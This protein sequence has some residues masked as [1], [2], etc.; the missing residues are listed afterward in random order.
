[1]K[2]IFFFF[3]FAVSHAGEAQI[4]YS[5][6]K[7]GKAMASANNNEV[8]LA[9]DVLQLKFDSRQGKLSVTSFTDKPTNR[10]IQFAKDAP[11]FSIVLP[12]GTR[13]TSAA[14][15][16]KSPIREETIVP[17]SGAAV[18]SHK[19]PGKKISAV[20][21]NSKIGLSVEWTAE[22]RDGSNYVREICNF[23]AS[24]P[25]E[26]AKFEMVAIPSSMEMKQVGT[27]DGSPMSDGDMF[28][29]VEHP[30][31]KIEKTDAAS[32]ALLPRSLPLIE[33]STFVVSAVWG[34]AP[35]DQLR[36]G[37]LYYV[38]RERANPYHQFLH[39]NSWY[40]LSYEDRTLN[41]SLC[42]DRIKV[43]GDSLITKRG[44]R[45]DAF[46]F[47]DGWDDYKTLWQ[48]NSGFPNGFTNLRNAAAKYHAG[49][50][51]WMSPWGGYDIRKPQRLAYGAK[52]DP[53]FETNENGFSLA[54]PV[55]Y[56]RFSEVTANFI[57]KYNVSIFKFDG[58]GAGNGSSG[59]TG[60]YQRDIESLIRLING[61]RSLKPDIFLSLTIGTWPSVYWLSYGDVIWRAGNDTGIRG[62]G[63]KR[64][65]WMN[66][67][68]AETYKNVVE[69]APL[70]PLGSLMYHGLCI[71]DAGLP[72]TFEMDN[73]DVADEMWSFF[74]TGTSLEEMYV[75]PHKLS[76][77]QWDELK[78]A[79]TWA[80]QHAHLMP[81]VHWIGGD[82]AKEEVYGYA[83]WSNNAGYLTLRN[84][85]DQEQTFIVDAKKVFELPSDANAKFLFLDARAEASD[86][87]KHVVGNGQS[88]TVKLQ[89]FQFMVLDAQSIK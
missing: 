68:D 57:T 1:M 15:V 69:R 46:L 41:D 14:F 29:A 45:M 77:Q 55:Y 64:Q 39:Y 65:Q 9:N 71:A 23:L 20:F 12:D 13:L 74:A 37:F 33:D 4:T 73:K 63:S 5:G 18:A 35:K 60:Q 80:R 62:K 66:Y 28:F 86:H 78:K 70:Y 34:V 38:E 19:L 6:K 32:I 87:K 49:I 84:P 51:V 88:I 76:S 8:S 58:V 26:I 17:S 3:L 48:F 25:L 7:P 61:L 42:L 43:F 30:L 59:A 54:G 11:L 56:K 24:R 47:D 89:P 50:G 72:G 81:D 36:R 53:P 75:N 79:I 16:I 21:E 67:R 10:S 40:D 44:V 83:A 22:L 31:A 27:V 82:P 85:S 52:Q 2:Y